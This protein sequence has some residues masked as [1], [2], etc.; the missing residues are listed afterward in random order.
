MRIFKFAV[1]ILAIA[2][3][4]LPAQA[5]NAVGIYCLIPVMEKIAKDASLVSF[6]DAQNGIIKKPQD[7]MSIE[8]EWE[9]LDENAEFSQKIFNNE[10]SLK[11]KTIVAKN[12]YFDELFLT[13]HYGTIIAASNKTSDYFQA[14]EDFF[15]HIIT[16]GIGSVFITSSQ[17]DKSAKSIGQKIAIP[18][19]DKNVPIGVLTV[20]TNTWYNEYF[21]ACDK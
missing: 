18:V 19:T 11:L 5:E 20:I 3:P 9:G 2:L 15:Q 4:T 14:D 7:T 8:K 16:Y 17:P 12:S 21:K 10:I 6:T 13:D 1:A